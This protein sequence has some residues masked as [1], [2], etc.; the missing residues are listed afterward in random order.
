MQIAEILTTHDCGEAGKPIHPEEPFVPADL[1]VWRSLDTVQLTQ[2]FEDSLNLCSCFF[3]V[4]LS[5][6]GFALF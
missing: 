1:D 3:Q 5:G 4:E 6:H 2:V